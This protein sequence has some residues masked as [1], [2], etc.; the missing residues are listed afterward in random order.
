MPRHFLREDSLT[1]AESKNFRA[2]CWNTDT[3][4]VLEQP[5]IEAKTS[6]C[7][8]LMSP[9]CKK[10]WEQYSYQHKLRQMSVTKALKP[11]YT[12]IIRGIRYFVEV[13]RV[14]TYFVSWG[15]IKSL[16]SIPLICILRVNCVFWLVSELLYWLFRVNG[17]CHIIRLVLL[18]SMMRSEN[19]EGWLQLLTRSY[20]TYSVFPTVASSCF[21]VFFTYM[22][23]S[24]VSVH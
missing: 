10:T 17:L 7:G 21:F 12:D 22:Y 2:K 20:N 18:R 1:C 15:N 3:R 8:W 9:C 14:E 6:A 13:C 4:N 5:K 19:T 24:S 23:L 11:D 16:L